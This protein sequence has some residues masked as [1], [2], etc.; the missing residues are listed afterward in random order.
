M[1]KCGTHGSSINFTFIPATKGTGLKKHPSFQ[2]K[3]LNGVITRVPRDKDFAFIAHSNYPNNVYFHRSALRPRHFCDL[4]NLFVGQKVCFSVLET[5]R[6][7]Q[8]IEVAPILL[9]ELSPKNP[10]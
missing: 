3:F 7:P 6:G 10:E 5:A 4:Q 2:S 1:R 8:A 9:E